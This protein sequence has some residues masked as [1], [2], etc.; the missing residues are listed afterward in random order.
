MVSLG[1]QTLV[2]WEK[3][4]CLLDPHVVPPGGGGGGGF[5]SRSLV[6][7][8]ATGDPSISARLMQTRRQEEAEKGERG[9]RVIGGLDP[10]KVSFPSTWYSSSFMR[11][12]RGATP[13][14]LSSAD[15]PLAPV[16]RRGRGPA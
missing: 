9:R 7:G 1:T 16:G 6:V 8:L 15:S 11:D 4:L 3:V 10:C 2:S 12:I 13:P 5:L 14:S